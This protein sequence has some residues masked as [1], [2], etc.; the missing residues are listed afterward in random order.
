MTG[1]ARLIIRKTMSHEPSLSVGNSA[2]NRQEIRFRSL[3]F[4]QCRETLSPF[5]AWRV[6]CR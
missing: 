3:R 4:R 2:S 1:K 6:P 5:W